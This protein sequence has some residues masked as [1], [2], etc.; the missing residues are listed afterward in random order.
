MNLS[1][2][3]QAA[4]R[5]RW[6]LVRQRRPCAR[7]RRGTSRS[8]PS[9]FRSFSSWASGRTNCL[10]SEALAD[11]AFDQNYRQP[12][13]PAQDRIEHSSACGLL[14]FCDQTKGAEQAGW[15]T[16]READCS[17]NVKATNAQSALE[18]SPLARLLASESD[19]ERR[20]LYEGCLSDDWE[21]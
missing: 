11:D 20:S 4:H 9:G 18:P 14:R 16:P 17:A 5:P 19:A 7:P 3:Y 21:L 2:A 6:G 12:S 8:A 10:I 13:K 1:Q 15:P